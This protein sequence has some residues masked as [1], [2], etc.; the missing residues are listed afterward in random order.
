MKAR[1]RSRIFALLSRLLPLV[2]LATA[3][4][5]MNV[6]GAMAAEDAADW[7]PA[8]DLILRYINFAI[9]MFLIFKYARKPLVNFFKEKS[10]D[11]KKEIQDVEREK[12]EILAKVEDLLKARD[13]SKERLEKLKERIIS[14]GRASKQR[15]IDS[16]QEE[17]T[18]LL[19]SA[20]RKLHS[21]LLS[22]H[23]DI[24]AEMIDLAIDMATRKLP[25]HIDDRDNQMILEHYMKSTDSL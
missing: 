17:G 15:I 5:F 13:H 25:D 16:A 7:R 3:A 20:K 4:M 14:Q 2:L 6:H 22:A 8:Y 12:K 21:Q 24:R 9:L 18:I 10:E 19:E 11:V 1:S 23:A